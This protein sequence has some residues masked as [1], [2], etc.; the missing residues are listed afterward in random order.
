MEGRRLTQHFEIMTS[1]FFREGRLLVSEEIN[2]AGIIVVFFFFFISVILFCFVLLFLTPS[3]Q[4]KLV[5][6]SLTKE[7]QT[8]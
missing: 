5:L 6:K 3:W 4:Y 7:I 1:D 2:H 8:S